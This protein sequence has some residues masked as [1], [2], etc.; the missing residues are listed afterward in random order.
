MTNKASTPKAIDRFTKIELTAEKFDKNYR[1]PGR[2]VVVTDFLDSSIDWNLDFLRRHLGEGKFAVRDYGEG[3]FD[4]PRNQWTKYC[5][6]VQMSI[7]DFATHITD[8]S[9]KKR[10]LYL[11]QNPIGETEAAKTIADE[12]RFLT[13]VLGFEPIIPEVSL[14][15]WLGPAGHA[16]PLHFDPGDGTMMLLHGQ[17][18]VILYPPKQSANLYPFGFYDVLPFWVSQVNIEDPDLGEHPNFN[19]A[20]QDR[21]EVVLSPG[22][23]LFIPTQWWHEVVA[24]GEGYVCSCNC[25]WKVKPLNR[26]FQSL[27]GAVLFA[28]NLLP[29]HWVLRFNRFIYKFK[30]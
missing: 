9:A 10:N 30:K 1:I 5:D 13:Q 2:P 12:M 29:W 4:A 6:H 16:E 23:V 3:H 28:M 17:K 25:F 15:L 24:E 26:K 8:G 22:Q 27:R 11:A 7:H 18:K 14:N 21:Y 19:K 20:Q